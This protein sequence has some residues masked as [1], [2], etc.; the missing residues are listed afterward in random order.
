LRLRARSIVALRS[1]QPDE[2]DD[3]QDGREESASDVHRSPPFES[4]PAD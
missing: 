2:E 4:T 1:E 3:D